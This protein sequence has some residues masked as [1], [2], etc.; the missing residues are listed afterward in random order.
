MQ[1]QEQ[2]INAAQQ[3]ILSELHVLAGN[4]LHGLSPT[5]LARELKVGASTVTR[6]LANLKEAGYAEQIQETGRWRLGPKVVQIGIKFSNALAR[7]ES[8]VSEL[9]QRYTRTA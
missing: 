5:E 7:A 2:Y 9:N 3:R 4:E 8:R 6:D 1:K